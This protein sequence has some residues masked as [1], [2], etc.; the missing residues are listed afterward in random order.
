M[1]K[2]FI[3]YS[4]ERNKRFS[5]RTYVRSDKDEKRVV[6]Q[7]V[8]REGER[9]LEHMLEA[10]ERLKEYYDGV[11]V[12]PCEMTAE[13]L[14][15]DFVEGELL[16]EQYLKAARGRDKGAY[17]DL[18]AFHKRMICGNEKNACAFEPN[19]EFREWFGE[20]DAYQGL[21]GLAYSNFD[22][23]AENIIMQGNMPTFIDY[24]WIMGFVMPRDLVVYHCVYDG[25]LHHS[26]LE[27]FYPFEQ[28]LQFLGIQTEQGVLEKSY[29]HFFEYVV[30][31]ELGR[32]YAKD[33]Y[34][35]LKLTQPLDFIL[36]EWNRC[37]TQWQKAVEANDKAEEELAYA[38]KEWENCA[39]QWKLASESNDKL[40]EELEQLR[41]EK[42]D[43][44]EAY[45]QLMKVHEEV[46]NSKVW[47]ANVKLHKM[48]GKG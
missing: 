10:Q 5:I 42:K 41:T 28:V 27:E 15:F 44:V 14:A 38:H 30:A 37:A 24:E 2:G 8:Y 17:E 46:V 40:K 21:P 18:L 12:C 22:A 32:S 31:D 1:K 7:A 13:G 11:R 9:H 16:L 33:K 3:K 29:K 36:E 20:D 48:I 35:C 23:I 4:D 47:R 25:Y 43:V 34:Q 45:E 26:E 6:K 39:N 19:E